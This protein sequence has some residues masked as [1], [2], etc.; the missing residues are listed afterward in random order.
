MRHPLSS[1]SRGRTRSRP[2]RI[3]RFDLPPRRRRPRRPSAREAGG[4]VHRQRRIRVQPMGRPHER[5]GRV[6]DRGA[7][8]GGRSRHRVGKMSVV[9]FGNVRH[10]VE[11][12][13]G[14][15][16]GRSRDLSVHG[17]RGHSR[18][19]REFL[20]GMGH[21]GDVRRRGG[22]GRTRELSQGVQGEYQ[23]RVHRDSRQSDHEIDR[24]GGRRSG[25][26]RTL[27]QGRRYSRNRPT[28]SE[29]SL[30]HGRRHLRHP[31]S[32]ARPRHTGSRRVHPFRHQVPRGTFR[33]SRRIGH[34]PLGALPP[35]M[36]QGAEAHHGPPQSHGFLPPRPGT[37]HPRRADATARR[38]RH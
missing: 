36:L 26:R 32:S 15:E 4:T 1:Q 16:G 18:I 33:H 29:A 7:G 8:G 37:P 22:E 21:R 9:Q 11:S 35:R 10:H 24:S 23:G 5:G 14:I 20:Q 31:V 28:R 13:V 38:E 6:S 30:G 2:P 12:H 3:L 19:R 17:V 27:R 25:R 34:V